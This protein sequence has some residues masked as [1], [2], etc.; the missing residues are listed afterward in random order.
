MLSR[1]D[2]KRQRNL[3]IH[4]QRPLPVYFYQVM[5]MR[6]LLAL[7]YVQNSITMPYLA[8]IKLMRV[9]KWPR[10]DLDSSCV[11]KNVRGNKGFYSIASVLAGRAPGCYLDTL[12]LNNPSLGH[13][14]FV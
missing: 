9:I 8:V 2:S 10:S 11:N 5:M 13:P 7:I 12:T 6:I 1:S 4:D 3:M 14:Y